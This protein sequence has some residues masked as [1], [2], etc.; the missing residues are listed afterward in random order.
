MTSYSRRV[1]TSVLALTIVFVSWAFSGPLGAGPRLDPD[2]HISSIW[3]GWGESPGICENLGPDSQFDGTAIVPYMFQFCEGRPL[4]YWNK[5]EAVTPADQMQELRTADPSSR[6]LYYKVMRVFASEN[7]TRSILAMRIFNGLIAAFFFGSLLT[8]RSIRARKSAVLAWVLVFVP[9]AIETIISL[10]PRSW[11]YVG[12]LSGWVFFNEILNAYYSKSKQNWSYSVMFSLSAFLCIASRWDSVYF[13]LVSLLVVYL[14]NSTS[15]FRQLKSKTAIWAILLMSIIA[16]VVN[17]GD[18]SKRIFTFTSPIS[19]PKMQ[20]FTYYIAN[21]PSII[22]EIWRQPPQYAGGTSFS[23]QILCIG[24]VVA[25]A[26][27]IF[28]KYPRNKLFIPISLSLVACIAIIRAGMIWQALLGVQGEYVLALI[29][30]MIGVTSLF[31]K[32][33][34]GYL[35]SAASKIVFVAVLSLAHFLALY[36]YLEFYVRRGIDVG[37]FQRI[38]L[39]G[40]WW[41]KSSIGPNWVLVLGAFSFVVFVSSAITLISPST[42]ASDSSH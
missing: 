32:A 41:W 3:C 28:E 15:L 23:I 19:I 33:T 24:L 34:D 40:G 18:F 10:N 12:V 26:S 36:N 39:S 4:D 17:V 20:F 31:A 2:H 30:V 8:I 13:F 9:V 11:S 27:K 25:W 29:G 35:V 6:N 22:G 7:A 37:G 38:S 21:M 42:S 14:A 16:V 1:I 5:C